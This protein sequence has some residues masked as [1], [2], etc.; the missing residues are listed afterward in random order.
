MST[1]TQ[2]P[3]QVVVPVAFLALGFLVVLAAVLFVAMTVAVFRWWRA[4]RHDV[5]A[6]KLRLLRDLDKHL[7][8]FVAD[9]PEVKAGLARLDA[10]VQRE[11]QEGEAA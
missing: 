9:D 2:P 3:G 5:G 10:A 6:D 7:D 8:R 4:R 11:R 1:A